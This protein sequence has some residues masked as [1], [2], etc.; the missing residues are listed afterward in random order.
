M[1]HLKTALHTLCVPPPAEVLTLPQ[2]FAQQLARPFAIAGQVSRQQFQGNPA[3][4]LRIV[5]R[6]PRSTG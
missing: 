5:N 6:P 1:A 2:G 4:E 3:G